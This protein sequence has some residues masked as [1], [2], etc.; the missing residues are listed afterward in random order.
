[1]LALRLD[2]CPNLVGLKPQNPPQK[3][4][5]F[6]EDS[7]VLDLRGFRKEGLSDIEAR[8]TE[9]IEAFNKRMKSKFQ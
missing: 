8:N 9:S 4:A 5:L 1:M 7:E 6:G 3:A 2:K